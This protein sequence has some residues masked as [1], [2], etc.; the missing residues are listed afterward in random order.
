M[1]KISVIVPVY[2]TDKYLQRCIDSILAQTF[3]DFE[4]ILID[5]G[6]TDNSKT[7]C[8]EYAKKDERVL[9]IHQENKGQAA[10]RN[11]GLDWVYANSGSEWIA[12][13]DSDDI[14]HPQMLEL[15]YRNII[16][17]D[18]KLAVGN[19]LNFNDEKNI[20][21][22]ESYHDSLTVKELFPED[23]FVNSEYIETVPWGKLYHRSCFE[24]IRYPDGKIHEDNFITYK[25][26][27]SLDKILYLEYPVYYYRLNTEST[28]KSSWTPRR[29]Y[30]FE[31]YSEQISF[32]DKND[33]PRAKNK[34]VF[35]YA[36][37]LYWQI[38][39]VEKLDEYNSYLIIMR[40]MMRRHLR[41]YK[42][43]NKLSYNKNPRFYS[44]AYP[45]ASKAIHKLH[46]VKGYIRKL[47]IKDNGQIT[48]VGKLYIKH[49][50]RKLT[51]EQNQIK[52]AE[53]YP[54]DFVVTWVDDTDPIW[55]AEKE[56]YLKKQ[57]R[58]TQADS[59]E[60]RYRNWD[61]LNY[62]F[63]AVEKYAPW[64]HRVFLVT[65]GHL[66]EW[67]NTNNSK[68]KV[69][70]HYDYIPQK[71]LPTFSSHTIENNL[72][73]IEGVSEHFVYFND[74]MFLSKEVMPDDFFCNGLPKYCALTKPNWAGQYLCS[75]DYALWNGI[76]QI[77]SKFS[78]RE[79]IGKHP[80]K[81]LTTELKD[82]YEY[83]S[84]T[85]RDNYLSGMYFSHLCTP[86][87]KSSMAECANVF[88]KKL[89]QTCTNKFRTHQDVNHQMFQMWTMMNGSFEPIE[90]G[91]YGF[92]DNLLPRTVEKIEEQLLFAD[93]LCVCINDANTF[94]AENFELLYNR[95][96]QMLSEKYPEKSTFEK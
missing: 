59:F 62:W 16:A 6:S 32:F 82:Y 10:A 81:W 86:F 42:S 78:L 76:G 85:Y 20:K 57:D 5:D 60:A 92:A 46:S 54:I 53:D 83:N 73:R 33:Y 64:V 70:N 63:R 31:A 14:C 22:D 66:P 39:E 27:F 18:C 38:R 87:R 29:L 49:K 52:K 79:V 17:A 36:N 7:I 11:V 51:K 95:L 91:Y 40:K 25:I 90:A 84:R 4:L 2:N 12:F 47:G 37:V 8:D 65:Y 69:I 96:H 1:S 56:G 15:L 44:A 41:N 71:Y 19:F 68:L 35:Q 75:F 24:S 94:T 13:T 3:T 21:P 34:V 58:Q 74:D 50:I 30:A 45:K 72:W 26:I 67:L 23:F 61:T 48:P 28:T 80:E 77:N 88:D 55:M 43:N 93:N 89:D 9:V